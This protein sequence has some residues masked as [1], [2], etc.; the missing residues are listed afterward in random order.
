MRCRVLPTANIGHDHV[1]TCMTAEITTYTLTGAL[2][3]MVFAFWPT[4]TL[5]CMVQ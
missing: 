5:L 1:Y 3:L 2:V 4:C